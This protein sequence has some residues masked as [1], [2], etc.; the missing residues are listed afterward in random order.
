VRNIA[1]HDGLVVEFIEA[2]QTSVSRPF[3]AVALS[4]FKRAG[5]RDSWAKY[6][7]HHSASLGDFVTS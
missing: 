2:E 6:R 3:F 1:K 4:S 5:L 7:R